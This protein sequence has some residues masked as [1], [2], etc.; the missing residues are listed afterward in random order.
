MITH[1]LDFQR[2]EGA[3][4]FGI[5]GGALVMGGLPAKVYALNH[6]LEN[7]FDNVDGALHYFT[8]MY[9]SLFFPQSGA[10]YL[11]SILRAEGKNKIMETFE[12]IPVLEN[13]DIKDWPW[14]QCYTP[15][16]IKNSRLLDGEDMAEG[17]FCEH[18][19]YI[20]SAEALLR[21]GTILTSIN[22]YLT[23][24]PDFSFLPTPSKGVTI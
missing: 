21:S 8:E 3:A 6:G 13:P 2:I 14:E 23:R 4:R 5:L 12:F 11:L 7:A 24:F 19:L 18:G 22:D 20:H 15:T 9:N 16:L 1:E 10:S 17:A